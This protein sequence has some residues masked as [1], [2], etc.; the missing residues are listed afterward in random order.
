MAAVA[1]SSLLV[2]APSQADL[3]WFSRANCINADDRLQPRLLLPI[4]VSAH[5][6]NS[7]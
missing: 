6:K 2:A 1:S 3:V 7:I 5:G 4:L